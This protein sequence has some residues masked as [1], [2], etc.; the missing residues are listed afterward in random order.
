[1]SLARCAG[2]SAAASRPGS[3]PAASGEPATP[4]NRRDSRDAGKEKQKNHAA[5]VASVAGFRPT[6]GRNG[7]SGRGAP[8]WPCAALREENHEWD[9][10]DE[11]HESVGSTD[12]GTENGKMML[13]MLLLSQASGQRVVGLGPAGEVRPDG[14]AR[15]S[16]KRI[17]NGTNPTNHTNRWDP[18]TAREKMKK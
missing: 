8:R 4:T 7:A 2:S 17:T 13:R 12:C 11:S 5:H 6:C 16:E 18:Q 10:P 1:M 9:E 3:V 14:P 15:R